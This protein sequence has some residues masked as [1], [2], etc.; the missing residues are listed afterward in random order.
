MEELC[1]PLRQ[2]LEA[3]QDLTIETIVH[4]S[5]LPEIESEKEET[6]DHPGECLRRGD[7]DLRPRS[8]KESSSRDP[9]DRRTRHI[10]DR[11]DLSSLFFH[12]LQSIDG[13]GCFS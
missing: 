12:D 8:S 7:P 1:D 2:Y 11:E 9:C 13:I 4:S 10:D 6:G 5:F 3:T